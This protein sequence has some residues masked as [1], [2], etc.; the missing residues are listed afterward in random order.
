[1]TYHFKNPSDAI[2]NDYLSSSRVIA[3]VGLSNREE[4]ASYQVSR[5][6]QQAGYTIIPVNPRLA[7][8]EILGQEV[9]ASL[10]DIPVAIDIVN[11]FRPS[12]VLPQVASD[13]IQSGAKI[14]WA[15]LGL[16]SQDAELLL[17]QAGK[18]KLVMNRCIKLDYLR[19]FGKP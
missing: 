15:Q 8:Q 16:E 4:T 3:V 14:F 7:G 5:V 13:F 6:M 9:Y 19:L 17:R 11:V 1:M 18:D 12:Q 2:I 10:L